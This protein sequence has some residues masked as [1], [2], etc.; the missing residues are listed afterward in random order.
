ML[1]ALLT[2]LNPTY[3]HGSITPHRRPGERFVTQDEWMRAQEELTKLKA[4]GVDE[5]KDTAAQAIK[6]VKESKTPIEAVADAKEFIDLNPELLDRIE[7]LEIVL[8][9]YFIIKRRRD[10]D[11][12][13]FALG[14][15]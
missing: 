4:R 3:G 12:A 9:A 14:I 1:A 13:L 7:C 6:A 2:N 5:Q 10:D 11:E 15:I 8:T